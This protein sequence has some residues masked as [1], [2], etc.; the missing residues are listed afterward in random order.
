M[1]SLSNMHFEEL[2]KIVERLRGPDGCPWDREQT[3]ET[4]IPFLIEELYELIDAFKKDDSEEIKEELGDLLFQLLLHCQLSKEEGR[5]DV[6]D[7]LK[8][9]IDKMIRRHPHV[10]G[11]KDLKTSEEVLKW[12]KEHKSAEGKGSNSVL[13][14]IPD[15]LPALLKAQKIQER[16]SEVG[17]DW[18][19]MDGALKKLEEEIHEFKKAVERKDIDEIEEELGDMLFV[20]VRLSN[21]V[22]V[23][24]EYALQMTINKFIKR[25]SHIENEALRQGRS[26]SDMTLEE[27]DAIWN[28]AKGKGSY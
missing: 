12:W 10:F 19:G 7:V 17:F 14:R 5:F 15:S 13:G 18:K 9:I 26:L 28:K 6:D 25:F 27:M 16:A 3:R 4:L 23:N 24:P 2:V 1:R 22:N 21:F 8:G 20:L 11:D